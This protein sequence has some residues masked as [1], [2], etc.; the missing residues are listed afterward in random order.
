MNSGAAP[1]LGS[2][3]PVPWAASGLPAAPRAP[4]LIVNCGA[5]TSLLQILHGHLTKQSF[6]E[7][8]F[9]FPHAPWFLFCFWLT[10]HSH[11][12]IK[13]PFNWGRVLEARCH[14]GSFALS[15]LDTT[16][17][18][19]LQCLVFLKTPTPMQT[20]P[21]HY[22]YGC[23]G[24]LVGCL[25]SVPW[26]LLWNLLLHWMNSPCKP[27]ESISKRGQILRDL[28]S[29]GLS[30]L[31]SVR[32]QS[33]RMWEFPFSCENL[34]CFSLEAKC[35]ARAPEHQPQPWKQN[36][37]VLDALSHASWHLSSRIISSFLKVILS[38]IEIS[39]LKNTSLFVH[40]V[41]K[42]VSKD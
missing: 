38:V 30:H 32:S 33:S 20:P 36:G 15:K 4:W 27:W 23:W 19:S 24:L 41:W 9:S 42:W 11:T 10:Q 3:M 18:R 34:H 14:V 12:S 1:G 22:C 40:S 29:S 26:T 13:C 35:N 8:Q 6:G 17:M 5:A 21:C 25:S 37:P 28:G 7:H 39:F 31:S 16:K 2:Y